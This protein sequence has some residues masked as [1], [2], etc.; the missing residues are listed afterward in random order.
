[1]ILVPEAI[2]AY[3]FD[4]SSPEDRLLNALGE[5]TQANA[6]WPQMQTGHVEGSFLRMLVQVSGAKRILEIGTYTGYSALS[7]AIG[8]P[9][10]GRVLTCDIDPVATAMARDYWSRSPHGTKIELKMGPA[11]ETIETLDGPFDFVF[12]DADK[13]NYVAYWEA[14]LPKVRSGGLIVVDNVLWSGNVLDPKDKSDFAIVGFNQHARSDD[15]VEL[16]LLTVRDGITVA[17]KR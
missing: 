14:V 7:M 11:L 2:E 15:R 4:H 10:G 6:K 13:E 12:I 5:D 8:L 17:R 1:M 16:V 9:D 3:A